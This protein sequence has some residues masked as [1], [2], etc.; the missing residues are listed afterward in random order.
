MANGLTRINLLGENPFLLEELGPDHLAWLRARN[1]RTLLPLGPAFKG[2][3]LIGTLP[4]VRAVF[5]SSRWCLPAPIF[6][7]Y[8]PASE[9][10]VPIFWHVCVGVYRKR[11]AACLSPPRLTP[12][13]VQV[14]ACTGFIP[15]TILYQD[16]EVFQRDKEGL[17][18]P[19]GQRP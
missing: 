6:T 17:E 16:L 3:F 10:F 7:A 12:H 2:I 14:R 19:L 15:C 13:A 18:L 4:Y 1:D 9:I 8:S 5:P 11:S